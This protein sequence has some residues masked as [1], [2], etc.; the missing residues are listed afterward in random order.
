MTPRELIYSAFRAA[1]VIK[2]EE[3]PFHDMVNDNLALINLIL[4]SWGAKE[5]LPYASVSRLLATEVNRRVYGI[6]ADADADDDNGIGPIAHNNK[7][8]DFA[9]DLCSDGV[10]TMDVPRQVVLAPAGDESSNTF[11]VTGTNYDGDVIREVITGVKGTG[12]GT[13][14]VFGTELFKTVTAIAATNDCAEAVTCGSASVID[15]ARPIKILRALSRLS[16][17]DT[18][19]NIISKD[20]YYYEVPS[21]A[22]TG[23]PTKLLYERSYPTGKITLYPEPSAVGTLLFDM[24]RPFKEIASSA[25]DTDINLPE[26]Y[27][28]AL[29]QTLIVLLS[30]EYDKAVT[31]DKEKAALDTLSTVRKLSSM[32]IKGLAQAT[33][34][35]V[36]DGQLAENKSL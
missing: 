6:I 7:D 13:V 9:G 10:A 29:R 34:K 2:T 21:K 18:P 25:L 19:I 16:G 27:I 36:V 4:G 35:A 14:S 33:P 23:T 15:I 1:G 32:S 22:T 12:V 24:W 26:V 8:C 31:V 28:L 30:P 5:L 20:R 11:T 3:T 17:A